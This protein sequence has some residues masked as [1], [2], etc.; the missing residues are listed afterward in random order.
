MI[1]VP[2][3]VLWSIFLPRAN[4]TDHL[5]VAARPETGLAQS[6]GTSRFSP[7]TSLAKTAHASG[8]CSTRIADSEA[9][10]GDDD[11]PDI[12]G[13]SLDTKRSAHGS[14]SGH[15]E[16]WAHRQPPSRAG[17]LCDRNLPIR[18]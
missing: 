11:A 14:W 18:C 2:I 6:I 17:F 12:G 1:L 8:P 4:A 16:R 13:D 10:E 5:V 9:S 3:V 15:S 7:G